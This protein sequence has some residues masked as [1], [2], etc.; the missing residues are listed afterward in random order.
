LVFL[1]GATG[2]LK[3]GE[4]VL[5]V[6]IAE[7]IAGAISMGFGSFLANK[8]ERDFFQSEIDRE[9]HEIDQFP[10]REKEEI[11]EIY[12]DRGFSPEEVQMIVKRITSDKKLWLKFMAREELGIV[13]ESLVHPYRAGIVMA[14][15]FIV[16]SIPPLLPYLFISH[17]MS[18]LKWAIPLSMA[19]LFGIGT[20]KT[21]VAKGSVWKDGFLFLALGSLAALLGY[22]LGNV[23]GNLFGL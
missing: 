13:S 11:R 18:A 3:E 10:E 22:L 2:A 5:L 1:R 14:A 4:Y 16:G 6:G 12:A 19:T 7:V 8:A 15:S 21:R 23:V 9:S 17:P 20:A